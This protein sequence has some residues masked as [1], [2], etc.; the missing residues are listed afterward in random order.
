M[1]TREYDK[2][3][4]EDWAKERY[5]KDY[6]FKD[7]KTNSKE[8][9]AYKSGLCDKVD[10]R[11]NAILGD[12]I[13]GKGIFM[14]NLR[15]YNK[16]QHIINYDI[17]EW[18]T[19]IREIYMQMEDIEEELKE[20]KEQINYFQGKIA[21]N[22]DEK[23]KFEKKKIKLCHERK[24]LIRKNDN[25]SQLLWDIN[26]EKVE[27]SNI[28]PTKLTVVEIEFFN[29]LLDKIGSTK[30]DNSPYC[31]QSLK[32]EGWQNMS[33]KEREKIIGYLEKMY[34]NNIWQIEE[35]DL[36]EIIFKLKNPYSYRFYDELACLNEAIKDFSCSDEGNEEFLNSSWKVLMK[37]RKKIEKMKEY[38]C[39][40][41]E[42]ENIVQ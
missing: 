11:I 5:R 3:A 1:N 26:D 40:I 37:L 27:N 18:K 35:D 29:F 10:K 23:E 38:N 32:K 34:I 16:E 8:R 28:F 15:L 22:I 36:Q 41:S 19:K 31:I 25:L 33:L 13:A 20:N 42:I 39:N 24:K 2:I 6:P 7:D 14:I 9:Y 4:F 30:K 17:N 21:S 12:L